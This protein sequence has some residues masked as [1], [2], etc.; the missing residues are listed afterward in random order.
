MKEENYREAYFLGLVGR[1]GSRGGSGGSKRYT[2]SE[3]IG[4][5]DTYSANP[6]GSILG[7]VV[8]ASRQGCGPHGSSV[9]Y[10]GECANGTSLIPWGTSCYFYNTHSSG[11][12]CCNCVYCGFGF[13]TGTYVALGSVMCCGGTFWR[14]IA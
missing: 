1:R 11:V 14:R 5:V 7:Q 9:T 10:M 12:C 8:Y 13:G 6:G 4:F 2:I 3:I